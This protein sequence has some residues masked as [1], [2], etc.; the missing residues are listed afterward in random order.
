MQLLTFLSV[1]GFLF[2]LLSIVIGIRVLRRFKGNL[3]KTI[4]YLLITLGL[5]FV[6]ALLRLENIIPAATI[7]SINMLTNLLLTFFIL[8]AILEIKQ[9]TKIIDSGHYKNK[10][11]SDKKEIIELRAKKVELKE[12]EKRLLKKL[13]LK[14]KNTE[15]NIKKLTNE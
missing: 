6:R 1:V 8:M 10:I 7:N 3:K 5:L 13:K 9:L 15:A 4:L 2:T 14:E 12:K 11:I